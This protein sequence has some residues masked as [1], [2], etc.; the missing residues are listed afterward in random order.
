MRQL[1]IKIIIVDIKVHFTCGELN[2]DG[3]AVNDDYI[4]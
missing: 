1:E 3:N 2:L 4:M